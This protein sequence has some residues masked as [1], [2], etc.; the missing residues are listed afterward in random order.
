MLANSFSAG[1]TDKILCS[2]VFDD[3]K[4]MLII[5]LYSP[6]NTDQ[7]VVGFTIPFLYD[8]SAN[9]TSIPTMFFL[10]QSKLHWYV[11]SKEYAIYCQGRKED[12]KNLAILQL[13]NVI[14]TFFSYPRTF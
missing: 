13:V 8:K 2:I 7:L 4:G 11:K 12:F 3:R 10:K 14:M 9:A 6:S 5:G 1:F